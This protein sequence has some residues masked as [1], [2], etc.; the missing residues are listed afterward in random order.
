MT[1][2]SNAPISL[3]TLIDHVRSGLQKSPAL[4]RLTRSVD[5]SAHLGELGDALVGHF[6]DESRREGATWA[7][8]GQ[9]LGVS[10]QAVQKRFLPDD[11][12]RLDLQGRAAPG[13][14]EVVSAAH[15]EAQRRRKTYLGT[16][17]LLLAILARPDDPATLALATCGPSAETVRAAVD[18]RIGIPTGEPLPDD[19]PF[20]RLAMT[21]LQHA[22]REALRADSATVDTGHLL[23]GLITVGAG[24]AHDVLVALGIGYEPLRDTLRNSAKG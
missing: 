20:T 7:Q 2:S 18:G 21:A 12:S 15:E 10:R 22:S 13:L 3:D 8:I 4:D 23:L 16:E 9:Q 14:Q 5:V 6:V 1:A 19:T 11:D 17:H 24:L